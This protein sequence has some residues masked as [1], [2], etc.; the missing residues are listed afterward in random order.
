M[1]GTQLESPRSRAWSTEDATG[2]RALEYWGHLVGSQFELE[3]ETP[4]RDRFQARIVQTDLGPV[5]AN[6]VQTERQIIR[7]T[8]ARIAHSRRPLSVL[9]Q[10]RSGQLRLRQVGR[11]AIIGPGECTFMDGT[12]PYE[13]ECLLPTSALALRFP[14][15]WLQCWIPHPDRCAARVFAGS[16]WCGALCAALGSLRVDSCDQLALPRALVAEHILGLLALAVGPDHRIS[17]R[18]ALLN[19]LVSTLRDR[20]H[21]P[22]LTPREVAA[23][24]GVST[25]SLHYA[26]SRAG[27]TFMKELIQLRLERA[28]EML[29]D[30]RHSELTVT[31]VAARCGFP[32][33]GHFARRF[34][35]RYAQAPL[36][37]RNWLTATRR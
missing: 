34:R 11:E 8:P 21:E 36:Q 23:Q 6:F 33:P 7:R 26:F 1:R 27:T 29:R 10:L 35:Q 30:D 14:Q 12:E 32:D 18:P 31:E 16:D 19:K 4:V 5:T 25:R 37:F 28:R 17:A 24:R 9:L 22:D 15:D 20:L 13:F 2:S 3:F